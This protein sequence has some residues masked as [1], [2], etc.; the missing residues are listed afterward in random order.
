MSALKDM[1]TA[2]DIG[3]VVATMGTTGTGTTDPLE[4]IIDLANTYDCRV[5]G[6]RLRRLLHTCR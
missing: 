1:L 2:G 4:E 5:H 6:T 3:T